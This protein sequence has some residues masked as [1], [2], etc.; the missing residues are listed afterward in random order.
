MI[1]RWRNEAA[2]AQLYDA[3]RADSPA[4]SG[5]CAGTQ[6]LNVSDP[7]RRFGVVRVTCEPYDW[8]PVSHAR[9]TN[10]CPLLLATGAVQA[11][12][13]PDEDREAKQPARPPR[14]TFLPGALAGAAQRDF[15]WG[16]FGEHFAK[17]AGKIVAK[18]HSNMHHIA[19]NLKKGFSDV[20][21]SRDR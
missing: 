17:T 10:R 4:I 9:A 14:P 11:D 16:R 18:M 5:R 19:D 7:V 21:S 3:V 12:P 2:S 15:D 1:S 13:A 20:F 8:G 6:L